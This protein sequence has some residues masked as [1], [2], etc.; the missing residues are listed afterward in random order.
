MSLFFRWQRKIFNSKIK[1]FSYSGIGHYFP[2]TRSLLTD[3]HQKIF[4]I[5]GDN[6]NSVVLKLLPAKIKSGFSEYETLF[7]FLLLTQAKFY[8]RSCCYLDTEFVPN[9]RFQKIEYVA[10]HWYLRDKRSSIKTSVKLF[11]LYFICSL[12]PVKYFLF[13]AKLLKEGFFWLL[14]V[15][16]IVFGILILFLNG[17]SRIIMSELNRVFFIRSNFLCLFCFITCFLA[18]GF[19][20]LF[21]V[22][23]ISYLT[24]SLA[25]STSSLFSFLIS[26]LLQTNIKSL[27][28]I[29]LVLSFS[30]KL[31][32]L[33]YQGKVCFRAANIVATKIYGSCVGRNPRFY[34]EHDTAELTSRATVKV[35]QISYNVFYPMLNIIAICL[36]AG[37]IS[38][39]LLFAFPVQFGLIFFV[40][41]FVVF[42]TKVTFGKKLRKNANYL[43]EKT[44]TLTRRL[45]F[46]FNNFFEIGL[47][48]SLVSYFSSYQIE[49]QKFREKQRQNQYLNLLPRQ[50]LEVSATIF[51]V[52]VI[53]NFN[54]DNPNMLLTYGAGF[55]VIFQKFLPYISNVNSSVATIWGNQAFLNDTQKFLE[56]LKSDKFDLPG[57]SHSVELA[58]FIYKNESNFNSRESDSGDFSICS[59]GFKNISYSWG[60]SRDLVISNLSFSLEKG[61]VVGVFGHLVAVKLHSLH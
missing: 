16:N 25:G 54:G 7:S 44:E 3:L 5:H 23:S 20:D 9:N 43:N 37:Y 28:L 36:S 27:C 31:F 42:L 40:F 35:S 49:D 30:L 34:S 51:G 45:S 19:V 17:S 1:N 13:D 60:L 26:E 6:F 21:L 48:K 52:L 57:D 46:D 32:G 14:A 55:A 38:V 47:A 39:V 53:F 2:F 59:L 29:L 8:I 58:G 61:D 41:V 22:A 12:M 11:L 10:N 18:L 24:A 56:N 4:K 33:Y 15:K 50:I